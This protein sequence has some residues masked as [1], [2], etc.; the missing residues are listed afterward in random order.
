MTDKSYR[1]K[2]IAVSLKGNKIGKAGDIVKGSEF[3]NL[4]DSLEGGFCVE[5]KAETKK[6]EP[7]KEVKKETKK[8]EPKK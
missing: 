1:I 7:K 5:V 2:A 8:E 3:I 6:E 4:S